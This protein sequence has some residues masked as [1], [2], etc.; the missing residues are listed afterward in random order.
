MKLGLKTLVFMSI[1]LTGFVLLGLAYFLFIRS[2]FANLEEDFLNRDLIR[3]SNQVKIML[4]NIDYRLAD[5][6]QWDDSYNFVEDKNQDYI[7]SN[8]NDETLA[9]LDID[10][11]IL[12]NKSGHIVQELYADD[13]Y[14]CE[15]L[16]AKEFGG[17]RVLRLGFDRSQAEIQSGLLTCANSSIL[18][19]ARPI[20]KSD[21]SGPA[22]GVLLFAKYLHHYISNLEMQLLL[23][24]DIRNFN[25][26]SM[27]EDFWMAKENLRIGDEVFTY[28]DQGSFYGY[29]LVQDFYDRPGAIIKITRP[30]DLTAHENQMFAWFTAFML[31]GLL[32]LLTAIYFFI[33]IVILRRLKGLY[34]FFSKVIQTQDLSKRAECDEGMLKMRGRDEICGL[35]NNINILLAMLEESQKSIAEQANEVLEINNKLLETDVLKEVLFSNIS[36]EL[37]TP[38]TAVRAYNQ[39]LY[40]ESFGKLNA[41]QKETL[42]IVLRSTDYLNSI[43]CELLELSRFEAGKAKLFWEPVDIGK[44]IRETVKE[45]SPKL[46]EVKGKV[47][48]TCPK[49]LVIDADS[50]RLKEIFQNLI[51]NSIKY[52]STRR[53]VIRI[54]CVLKKEGDILISVEDNARGISEDDLEHMFD[55][56]YQIDKNVRTGEFES[57][58]LGLSIL[59]HIVEAHGGTVRLESALDV[60]TTF[61]ITLPVKKPAPEEIYARKFRNS[62]QEKK[63]F[64]MKRDFSGKKL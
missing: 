42:E 20:L 17:Q 2:S 50:M 12:A 38:L 46:R 54:N 64:V 27:A 47:K 30:R 39:L 18:F 62:R 32:I 22:N 25:D 63:T 33:R 37:K 13:S 41:K 11:F 35:C 43:I 3:T 48:V 34:D 59:K 56:F 23:D 45:F 36:H 16:F 51:S 5:W 14:S 26:P 28:S 61:F 44:L 40:D 53:L 29:L 15:N 55:R 57:T 8:L 10:M 49:K 4:E 21:D 60:G 1:V 58:G 9:L 24:V 31:A 7:S 6:S 19:V 52:K